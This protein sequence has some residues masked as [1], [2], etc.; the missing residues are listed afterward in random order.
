MDSPFFAESKEKDSQIAA[1]PMTGM[2]Q[3]MH[4]SIVHTMQKGKSYFL[5]SIIIIIMICV[6]RIRAILPWDM[7]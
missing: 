5:S 2:S 3:V 4:G 1:W 6:M 7:P